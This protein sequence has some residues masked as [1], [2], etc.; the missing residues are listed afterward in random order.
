MLDKRN[1]RDML[2]ISGDMN[3]KMGEENTNYERVMGKHGLGV[4]NGNGEK[5][6][7]MCDMNELFAKGTLFPHK[8]IHKATWISP[9]GRTRNQIDHVLINKRFRNSIKDTRVY[10]SADLDSDHYL[11]CT[12]IRLKLKRPPRQ[13]KT[14]RVKY[15]TSKLGNEDTLKEFKVTLRNRY[16]VLQQE[17]GDLEEDQHKVADT[18]LGNLRKKKTPWIS[19]ESWELVDQRDTINKK[20]LST[21]SERVKNQLIAKYAEKNKEV[22]RSIKSDKGKWLN[23][24]ASQAEEAAR[25]QHMKTL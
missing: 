11:V 7:D 1:K 4:R 17:G 18:V 20:S 8:I 14:G 13:K 10:R 15:D 5:L 19:G 6:C 22:K 9:D 23:N 16:Q 21:H 12:T 24:I 25:S 3:A 2:V